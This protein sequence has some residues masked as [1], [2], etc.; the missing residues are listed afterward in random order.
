MLDPPSKGVGSSPK[1]RWAGSI[2]TV[3]HTI[4]KAVWHSHGDWYQAHGR[5]AAQSNQGSDRFH[6]AIMLPLQC[7]MGHGGLASPCVAQHLAPPGRSRGQSWTN[8]A[9]RH[10]NPFT[11]LLVHAGALLLPYPSCHA[12]PLMPCATPHAMHCP[13][14]HCELFCIQSRGISSGES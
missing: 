11:A 5:R 9:R 13:G 14:R 10:P 12:P 3:T 8:T 7:C 2:P 1:K 6:T 4:P